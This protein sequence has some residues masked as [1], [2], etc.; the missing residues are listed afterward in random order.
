MRRNKYYLRSCYFLSCLWCVGGLFLFHLKIQINWDGGNAVSMLQTFLLV[1]DRG[2][3]QL[4]FFSSS[5]GT[6]SWEWSW[7]LL[8]RGNSLS[9]RQCSCGS[10]AV[11]FLPLCV[12]FVVL[13]SE[14]IFT[15]VSVGFCSENSKRD[16]CSPHVIFLSSPGVWY[17]YLLDE[18]CVFAALGATPFSACFSTTMAHKSWQVKEWQSQCGNLD[19]SLKSIRCALHFVQWAEENIKMKRNYS[20]LLTVFTCAGEHQRNW[21]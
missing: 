6:L 8:R 2:R 18:G 1:T 9:D 16:L 13:L 19:V 12:F 14:R 20:A 17:M 15:L 3:G 4:N 11:A 10:F 21:Q 7:F 5:P